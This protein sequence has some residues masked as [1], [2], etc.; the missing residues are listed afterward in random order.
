MPLRALHHGLAQGFSLGELEQLV[1]LGLGETWESV[2]PAGATLDQAVVRLIEWA[3]RTGRLVELAEAA[4]ALRPNSDYLRVAAAYMPLVVQDGRRVGPSPGEERRAGVDYPG[5]YGNQNGV[6][7]SLGRV[8]AQ[9]E[10]L[11][12]DI[13]AMRGEIAALR[14]GL[15]LQLWLWAATLG[16]I[17]A[18]GVA[19]TLHS[20]GAG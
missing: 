13:A 2:T 17:A 9:G 5:Q 19:L 20:W 7:R 16:G 11:R 12:D 18:L 3:Q 6:E 8:E 4:A 1:V 15:R 14:G 10:S